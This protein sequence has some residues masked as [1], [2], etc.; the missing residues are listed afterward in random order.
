MAY[1]VTTTPAPKTPPPCGTCGDV[2][3]IYDGWTH[4]ADGLC[5][6]NIYRCV[7]SHHFT[8]IT[9]AQRSSIRSSA[10]WSN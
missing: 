5:V 7:S 8:Y 4:S 1:I 2:N 9:V 6:Q 10:D 3:T